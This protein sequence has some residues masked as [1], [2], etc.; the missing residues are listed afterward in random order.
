VQTCRTGNLLVPCRDLALA[1][2]T[3][4]SGKRGTDEM[5]S[6]TEVASSDGSPILM[7]ECLDICLFAESEL[8]ES[9]RA[10]M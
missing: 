3:S 1:G 5:K 7:V 4:R 6:P 2:H 10:L 9:C 8:H